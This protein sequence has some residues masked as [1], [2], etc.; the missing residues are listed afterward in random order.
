[1]VRGMRVVVAPDKFKGSLTAGEAAAAIEAGLRRAR[2][3]VELVRV[4]VAD[5]GDGTLAVVLSTGTAERVE[6]RATGPTGEPVDAA[7]AITG[8]TAMV[9]MAEASGLRRLPGGVPAPLT[10]TT[11]GT[12]ELISA[13]LDRGVAK[14]VLGIGGSATNDGGTGMA[15]A[16]GA[17]FL[18]KE[19]KQLPPGGAALMRLAKIE[20]GALDPRLREVEVTVACDVD[21]PLVG[22][23]GAAAVFGPQKGAKPDDVLLLDSALR[24]YARALQ[25]DLGLDL[26]T[27]PGT[28]AAGGLGAGAIAFLGAELKSGIQLVL[29]LAG[30]ADAIDGAD[31]V[32]TGEGSL[33]AQSLRGKAPFGVAQK[34]GEHGVPVVA[35]AGVIEVPAKELRA[36]GFEEGHALSSL[37]PDV[38][39]SKRNAAELLERLAEKVGRAWSSLP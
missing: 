9:E 21:N 10:A 4:P 28:G 27:V 23:D 8:D 7:I 26:V 38:E 34:A 31:L 2:P 15:T 5:G 25:D 12:G 18:D 19:G 36:A 3:D 33:D 29:D 22:P 30:F 13:A 1:M 20:A 6:V 35:L 14:L 39:R 17:R 32:I 16:L 11:Y 24:R 37:E